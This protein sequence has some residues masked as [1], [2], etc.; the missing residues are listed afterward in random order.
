MQV[1]RNA[2]CPC[3]SGKKFKRCCLHGETSVST[4]FAPKI[5]KK[6]PAFSP[7]STQSDTPK[8]MNLKTLWEKKNASIDDLQEFFPKE[9]IDWGVAQLKAKAFQFNLKFAQHPDGLEVV[10]IDFNDIPIAVIEKGGNV[11]LRTPSNSKVILSFLPLFCM[12]HSEKFLFAEKFPSFEMNKKILSHHLRPSTNDPSLCKIYWANMPLFQK[13]RMDVKE[14]FTKIESFNFFNTSLCLEMNQ[15]GQCTCFPFASLLEEEKKTYFSVLNRSFFDRSRWRN[16]GLENLLLEFSDKTLVYLGHLPYHPYVH[17]MPSEFSMAFKNKNMNEDEI[18]VDKLECLLLKHQC[19]V[20]LVESL[21]LA[22]QD[23]AS[24]FDHRYNARKELYGFLI[25]KG[26]KIPFDQHEWKFCETKITDKHDPSFSR[27]ALNVSLLL[28]IKSDA[29]FFDDYASLAFEAKIRTVFFHQLVEQVNLLRESIPI[30]ANNFTVTESNYFGKS[31]LFYEAEDT[32]SN[33]LHFKDQLRQKYNLSLSLPPQVVLPEEELRISIELS[34]QAKDKVSFKITHTEPSKDSAFL[35]HWNSSF[36]INLGGF[37]DGIRAL[38]D[39]SHLELACKSPDSQ[40]QNEL[41]LLKHSGAFYLLVMEAFALFEKTN[42]TNE[43]NNTNK[44]SKT[45]KVM[46]KELKEEFN[47]IPEKILALFDNFPRCSTSVRNL[48]VALVESIIEKRGHI[49]SAYDDVNIRF[50]QTDLYSIYIQV[51]KILSLVIHDKF[52]AG[53]VLKQN[54]KNLALR[55]GGDRKTLEFLIEGDPSVFSLFLSNCSTL[56]NVDLLVDGKKVEEMDSGELV[57]QVQLAMN[58]VREGEFDQKKSGNIDW[59]ELHP[60]VFFKGKEIPFEDAIKLSSQHYLE[61]EGKFYLIKKDKIPA[62]EWLSYFWEKLQTNKDKKQR[63]KSSEQFFHLPKSEVLTML[64]LRKAGVHIEGGERWEKICAE[65]DALDVAH[66]PRNCHS[67]RD[68]ESVTTVS[69]LPAGLTLPLRP[70]QI[71]GT[72]WLYRLYHLELGGILADEMGLGKTV[73]T[74]AFFECLRLE[75]KIGRNLIILPTSLVYNWQKEFAR[76]APSITIA[77][78]DP[79]VQ[80][81]EQ[82]VLCTYGLLVRHEEKINAEQWNCVFFDEAQSLKNIAA[83]RTTAA[84]K[85]RA[86]F[87]V[88]VTGTPL[89]NH[90]GEFFSLMDLT[91]PGALGNH[92]EF[93]QKFNLKE[94]TS[95]VL[96]IDF[97]DITFL[98]MTVAPLVL[99]RMKKEILSELPDKTETVVTLPFEKNQEKIYKDIAISWNKRVREKI[100]NEGEAKGQLEMLTALLRLRQ[101]CSIP[102]ILPNVDYKGIP[103]KVEL[104][105]EQVGELAEEGENVLVFTNFKTTLEY[106]EKEFRTK[107]IKVF[108]LT[109]DLTSKKRAETLQA[110]EDSEQASVF[111]MTLKTG[112]VGLNLT[113]ASYVF[114]FEP[115]WNPQTENQATDRVHRIGQKNKV[116]VYRYIIQNSVEEKIQELKARKGLAFDALFSNDFEGFDGI[117]QNLFSKGHITQKDFEFLLQ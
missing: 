18:L 72:E 31:C 51:L 29:L 105:L 17:F 48:I 84:R 25:K 26:E 38:S 88:A 75:G 40:R 83:Q 112:G 42:E 22:G 7:L 14:G 10:A 36:W 30:E 6:S 11:F 110:F 80:S 35:I 111:L 107:G 23:E 104:L 28:P 79:K 95:E 52:I 61:H 4:H 74:I 77:V 89:E 106:L 44:V 82:V 90:F 27:L 46:K 81:K 13:V 63:G 9:R 103:P 113:K 60:K 117:D 56:L 12:I 32:Y 15:G 49:F 93:M 8:K 87:K 3:G 99:R 108:T 33:L 50:V 85:L 86:N 1:P 102:S 55:K 37:V 41:K 58:G 67:G 59:F 47:K 66:S 101:A 39:H 91:V 94:S 98:K 114:H 45:D 100:K 20:V 43:K 70:F 78:F 109:G 34:L 97:R 53:S 62:I 73:Q 69:R 116:Q 96:K 76:F 68:T 16:R 21:P 57:T 5:L 2:P 24:L 65:F 19:P 71:T 115:W 64:A 92:G 54:F